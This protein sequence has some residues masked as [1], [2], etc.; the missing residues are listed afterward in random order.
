MPRAH[1]HT[2][3][4]RKRKRVMKQA[5]GYWGSRSTLYRT[6]LEAVARAE[7]YATIHRRTRK[8]DFRRLWILRISAACRQLG[9]NYSQF[10]RG[11][12]KA[13]IELNRKMLAEL[14]V[15]DA[16]GFA[17]LVNRAQ[18]ALSGAG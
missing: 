5:S 13:H 16:D 10:I 12:G 11:L 2:A 3:R 8:R 14:A 15:R 6:A 7:K 4:H 9:T 1:Y 17:K 18:A